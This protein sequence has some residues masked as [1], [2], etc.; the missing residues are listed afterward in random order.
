[1]IDKRHSDVAAILDTVTK[2]EAGNDIITVGDTTYF[3]NDSEATHAYVGGST[4]IAT[5]TWTIT[6]YDENGYTI[7]Q[8]N[9]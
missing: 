9:I 6:C 4:Y 2:D 7:G 8:M 3:F 5:L 1:M